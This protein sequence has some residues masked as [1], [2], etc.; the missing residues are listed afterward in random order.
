MALARVVDVAEELLDRPLMSRPLDP[1]ARDL[2]RSRKLVA[3]LW[4]TLAARGIIPDDWMHDDARRYVTRFECALPEE[5]ARYLDCV[6]RGHMALRVPASLRCVLA[7]ASD[8]PGVLRAEALA[9]ESTER[10]RVLYTDVASAGA[11]ALWRARVDDYA[12]DDE[13]FKAS[14]ITHVPP[15]GV[16]RPLHAA[17]IAAG[18]DDDCDDRD[19]AWLAAMLNHPQ[20]AYAVHVRYASEDAR[21]RRLACAEGLRLPMAKGFARRCVGCTFAEL[22]DP[23]TP[24]LDL[25]KSGCGV[26]AWNDDGI[27]LLAPDVPFA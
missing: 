15:Y 23:Y 3:L 9:R 1:V 11:L 20:G 5:Q 12:H 4:E 7:M 2:P 19:D 16:T 17:T 24:L 18:L 26:D 14:A 10:F 21:R 8:V 13:P 6:G 22:P 27:A 25:W